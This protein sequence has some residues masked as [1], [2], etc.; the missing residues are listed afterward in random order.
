LGD[1]ARATRLLE[2]AVFAPDH[3]AQTLDEAGRALGFDHF[4]LV[5][6]DLNALTTVASD[7]SVEA[8]DLYAKGGWAEVDYR[9]AHVGRVRDGKLFLDHVVVD[10]EKR[11]G[12]P[13]YHD[14]YVPH[15]MAYY[16]GWRFTVGGSTWNLALARSEERGPVSEE[17]AKALE[18]II[19]IANRSLYLIHQLRETHVKGMFDGL[20]TSQ[21]A[22]VML[23]RDGKVGLVTPQAQRLFNID[24]DIRDGRLW[25]AH[26]ASN[27]RLEKV[28]HFARS[29]KN[30]DPTSSFLIQRFNDSRTILAHP[31]LI[32]GAGVDLLAGPRVALFLST[33][34]QTEMVTEE[35][36]QLLYGLSKAEAQIAYALA[37]G[38]DPQE[39]AERRNVSVGTIRVQMKNIFHKANVHRQSE[40][41]KAIAEIRPPR[42]ATSLSAAI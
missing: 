15:R 35:D 7:T 25:S 18:S 26:A 33:P 16:A 20:T 37:E 8:F 40:L 24:F 10:A 28:A 41:I 17:E 38:L 22:A 4:C 6:D 12:N 11:L 14:L 27:A 23:H 3:L 21:T 29:G 42:A 34:G 32:Q 1:I 39:V 2:E 36:L 30:A 9:A 31:V 19:P 13:V 5:H